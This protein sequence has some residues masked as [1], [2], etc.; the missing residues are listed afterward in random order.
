MFI[1]IAWISSE[2]DDILPSYMTY[3]YSCCLVSIGGV[4]LP[5]YMA[6][7]YFWALVWTSGVCI[8]KDKILHQLVIIYYV[9][10]L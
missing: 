9:F 4:F 2:D 5:V 3:M 10:V 8:W 1:F 7:L 6:Y